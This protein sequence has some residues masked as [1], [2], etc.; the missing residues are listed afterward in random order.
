MFGDVLLFTD[1]KLGITDFGTFQR[2]PKADVYAQ[3]ETDLL[4]AISVLR[5]QQSQQGRITK[6]AAQAL[7]GKVYLYQEKFDLAVPMLENVVNGPFSLVADYDSIFL[8]EG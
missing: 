1:D 8:L 4:H 6:Y 3:I 5:Q 2:A 7:L